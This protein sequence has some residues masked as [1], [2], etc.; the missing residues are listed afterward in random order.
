MT[1]NLLTLLE[2]VLASTGRTIRAVVLIVTLGLVT[3]TVPGVPLPPH[4]APNAT[5]TTSSSSGRLPHTSWRKARRLAD[6]A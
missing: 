3:G 5:V 6:N 2:G 4:Q 1:K